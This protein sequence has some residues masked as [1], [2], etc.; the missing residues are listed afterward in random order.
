M[1]IQRP[2]QGRQPP[3][4]AGTPGPGH[5]RA[6]HQHGADQRHHGGPGRA[7]QRG[8]FDPHPQQVGQQHH[9]QPHATHVDGTRPQPPGAGGGGSSVVPVGLAQQGVVQHQHHRPDGPGRE[10]QHMVAHAHLPEQGEAHHHQ[11]G[12]GRPAGHRPLQPATQQE[13]QT[14]RQHQHQ[15]AQQLGGALAKHRHR[16]RTRLQRGPGACHFQQPG[17]APED[18]A[19]EVHRVGQL[20]LHPGV[21]LRPA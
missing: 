3:R 2:A 13:G 16:Q 12:A 8:A 1:R 21:H 17:Q 4:L 9:Q 14:R 6:Q 19:V 20:A 7:P 11:R 5:Q 15:H 18:K 10:V